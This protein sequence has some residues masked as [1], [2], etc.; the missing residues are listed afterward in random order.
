MTRVNSCFVTRA[1]SAV[2]ATG[3]PDPWAPSLGERICPRRRPASRI[4][5]QRI[6]GQ[7]QR[8]EIVSDTPTG[9]ASKQ[10][11]TGEIQLFPTRTADEAASKK[12]NGAG[13]RGVE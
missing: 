8:R 11:R 2:T 5:K 6:L 12:Q 3:L 10:A 4:S 1:T 9:C 13:G 7:P